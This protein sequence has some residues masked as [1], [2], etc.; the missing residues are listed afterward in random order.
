MT[1]YENKQ[2]QTQVTEVLQLVLHKMSYLDVIIWNFTQRYISIVLRSVMS[3]FFEY[4]LFGIL[5]SSHY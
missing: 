2:N 3:C 5:V 1:L 4:S